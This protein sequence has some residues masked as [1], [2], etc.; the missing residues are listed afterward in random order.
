[1]SEQDQRTHDPTP[2][3][4]RRAQ[5]A[6]QVA[7]SRELSSAIVWMAG[8]ALL[9]ALATGLWETVT[10]FGTQAWAQTDIQ[11]SPVQLL[12][13]QVTGTGV[14]FWQG[15]VP[16]VAG[17]AVISA[18]VWI[19]QNG[20]R[21]TPSLVIPKFERI[22]PAQNLRR[23]FQTEQWTGILLGLT[24]FVIMGVVATWIIVGDWQTLTEITRDGT[25]PKQVMATGHWIQNA[26]Q[27]LCIGALVVG[28]AD[29]GIRWQLT[30]R[31]LRM[32]EQE[33]RDEQRAM[34]ASPEIAARRRLMRR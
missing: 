22:S 17:V 18:I 12:N 16:I 34:E 3:R 19:G 32:T 15:L 29:F 27:R 4:L 6:G 9:A 28:L 7:R 33:V 5:D 30:R 1:M 21:L 25:L 20:F 31:S 14:V 13:Q 24:K 10:R 23:M 8:L 2:S 26:L 11:R